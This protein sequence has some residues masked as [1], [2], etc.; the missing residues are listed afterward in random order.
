MIVHKIGVAKKDCKVFALYPL[1]KM[2]RN[3]LMKSINNIVMG[4]VNLSLFK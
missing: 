3:T 4:L 1:F 2:G